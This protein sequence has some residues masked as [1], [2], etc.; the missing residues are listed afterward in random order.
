M[1]MKGMVISMNTEWSLDVF[2]K[3]YDDPA[4]E[5]DLMLLDEKAAGLETSLK[6]ART[7]NDKEGLVTVLHAMED[8]DKVAKKTGEYVFLR[9]SVDT[10]DGRTKDYSGRINRID[11]STTKAMTAIYK[12]I[13]G[14]EDLEGCIKADPLLSE[15]AFMLRN[16]K[17]SN[18]HYF[19]DDVEAM[20]SKMNLSGG[21]AWSNMFDYLTSTVKA[22]YDGKELTLPQVRNLAY[23]ADGEVRKKAYNA[24]LACYR[25]IEGSIA[26]ALNSIKSQVSMLSQERGYESPLAMTLEQSNMKQETLEAM[27]SAMQEYLPQFHEYLRAKAKYL[28][29]NGGLPWYD[30]FAPLGKAEKTYTIEEAKECLLESFGALSE[31]MADMMKCA[32]EEGWIDFYPHEGKVGG[33]FCEDVSHTGESR[34]LTNFNGSFDAVDTLAHELGHAYHATQTA[35]HRILN[36]SYP[37]QVAETASTFNETHITIRAINKAQGDEKLALLDNFLTNTTQTICDIYSRFLFEDAVF[38]ACSDRFLMPEDLKEIM[39]DAQKKAYGDGLDSNYLH[40]YMW[41]CKGH[42]YSESLSYYN[43]P[44]AFGTMLAMGLYSQYEKEGEA[45]IPKYNKFLHATSVMSV[46]DTVAVAGIDVTSKDFWRESLQSFTKLIDEFVSL[47][48][49]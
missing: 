43:F 26:F 20:V 35:S 7:Q 39:L 34:I 30:M 10:T 28:G 16:I 21:N 23:D 48:E 5:E 38:G 17:K 40:P 32:F 25:K 42:Y 24:E 37:M 14:V 46:E 49:A 6:K 9:Q 4:F 11:A 3:G 22:D 2:Y 1:L 15:Y 36:R 41:V 45:F 12:Y 27:F 18:N 19:S 13:A 29:Y 44:Y 8:Y 31:D 33:A 47:V